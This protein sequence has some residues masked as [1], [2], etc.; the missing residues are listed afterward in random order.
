MWKQHSPRVIHKTPIN[1]S[2]ILDRPPL[3]LFQV[4]LLP[5]KPRSIILISFVTCQRLFLL[6][7]TIGQPPFLSVASSTMLK[8]PA[9]HQGP[10]KVWPIV[11][12][13]SQKTL[14]PTKVGRAYRVVSFQEESEGSLCKIHLMKLSL[15]KRTLISMH[16][17]QPR[18]EPPNLPIECMNSKFLKP[19]EFI[20]LVTLSI[21]V[22]LTLERKSTVGPWEITKF[23]KIQIVEG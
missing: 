1:P 5:I 22:L 12:S 7:D 13:E 4:S 19:E 3:W 10:L 23:L 2:W 17:F 6:D 15:A 18:S 21:L 8:S 9:M 11:I 20:N 16:S 14:W